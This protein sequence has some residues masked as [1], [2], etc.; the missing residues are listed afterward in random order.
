MVTSHALDDLDTKLALLDALEAKLASEARRDIVTFSEMMELP[1]APVIASDGYY[2]KKLKLAPHHRL[3]LRAIQD[4]TDSSDLNGL[5]IMMPPGSAK[6]SFGSVLVPAW[7]LGR[8]PGTNVIAVTYGQE[9]TIRFARRVRQ[10]CRDPLYQKIMG[11]TVADDNQAVEQWSLTNGSDY[12]ASAIGAAI[13]GMRADLVVIDDPVKDREAADSDLIQEKT[14]AAYTDNIV[15]RLK[16]GGKLVVIATRWHESDLIGRLLGEKW[17]GQSGL[18]RT[19]DDRLMQ[20]INLPMLAEHADDPLGRKPGEMLWK[21]HFR[22]E[23]VERLRKAASRGGSFART[24][25]SLYQQRPAPNEGAILSR[26]YWRVWDKPELPECDQVYLCY[27]TAFEEDEEADFSAMTAWGVFDSTSR[28]PD[29]KEYSHRHVILLGAWEDKVS[30]VDLI[31]VVQGHCK[32]FRPDR[33]LVE[34]RASGIQLVQEMKRRRLPVQDWLPRGKPGTKGKVPRAHA[35]A[36]ILEMGSV[37]YVPG[38]KT[39]RV[40]EQCAAFPYGTND[41]LCLVAGTLIATRRG[42]IPI[43]QVVVG[44]EALTPLG[45]RRVSAAGFTGV[46]DVVERGPLTGTWNHPVFHLQHGYVPLESVD[47]VTMASTIG[48]ATLWSLIRTIRQKPWSSTARSTGAWAEGAGTTS[49]S[50]G[51]TPGASW[52]RGCTSRSG[53][54]RMGPFRLATRSITRTAIHLIVA[55]KIWTAYRALS[56]GACTTRARLSMQNLMSSVRTWRAFAPLRLSGIGQMRD[57]SGIDRMPSEQANSSPALSATRSSQS[58]QS[59]VRFAGSFSRGST[60]GKSCA[61]INATIC[62]CAEHAGKGR[63]GHLSR[64]GFVM[65]AGRLLSAVTSGSSHAPQSAT[66]RNARP[67]YNLTVE[68]AHCYYANGVLVHNCDTVTMAL[69]WFRDYFVFRTAEDELD[70]DELKDVLLSRSDSRRHKRSLYSG[71][72]SRS[73]IDLDADD[74][75]RMTP[76]TRRRLYGGL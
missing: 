75:E 26:S 65:F 73:R 3:L 71:P 63:A 59:R 52:R 19:S 31:D 57:E 50:L 76:D 61:P 27:D 12:R 23:E 56:I 72:V 18:W 41:D 43:E 69:S 20:V 9:L 4:L 11:C 5:I 36:A 48:R 8:R 68:G 47:S 28:K 29:G 14:W 49:V 13:T 67:V 39:E 54:A 34:K 70:D 10:V 15:T 51:A 24:W 25:S 17:K 30:A 33:I 7:V 22:A 32:L 66:D 40:L 35:V 60:L 45:W 64:C 37:W 38:E 58:P 42:F 62:G 46:R 1:G 2:P 55:W 21:D 16:P 44:D 6:S 53:R 74:I